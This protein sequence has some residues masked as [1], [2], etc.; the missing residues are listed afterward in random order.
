MRA[1]SAT[2]AALL[3]ALAAPANAQAQASADVAFDWFEYRGDDAVFATPL[4]A[5][6]YRNPVLAG[7][8]PDPSITRVGERYYLVNSTFTYF[9]A[10]PVFESTDLVHWTQIG[11]VV[12]RREQLDY[13]GLRMSRGMYAASIRHHDGRF[14]V[15][16]TSVDSGGNFIASAGD[17]AGPWSTLTWLPSIDGIDPSLFFDTD[18]SVYLLNN[19]PP[20][21]TP[22]YEGHR[23]IWMQRFDIATNQPVGPRKVLLNGGVDLA[24]KPIWIEGPH[25]YQRDG[26][27]YLSCAEGGTGPQHSQVVLRSRSVW[28]PYAPAP[29]NP[30]LTQRDL[31]AERAHPISNAGHVDLVDTSDGQWWAVFLASRPYRGD[32][33]NTGRE[34]FLLPVQWRDGWPSILP[35]GQPI[36]YIARAPAGM[37]APATQ[38]PLS[39]NFVWHDDFDHTMLQREWLTVRVPKHEVAD[40]RTRAGWL[41]LHASSQG[42]DGTGTPAFLA[43][44]QQHM[45]FTASTALEVPTQAGVSAGL[46]AFQNSTAWYALGI[47]RD[48]DAV[49][50]F[51]DKRD[52]AAT[53]TLAQTRIPATAQLRLQISGDGGAY[54]FAFDADGRGWQSLRRNDDA[55][56]LSTEKAGGFVGSVIGPFAQ[57]H[58]A[59]P[60]QD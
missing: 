53:T 50:V 29:N 26:W 49:Q 38:A 45:R 13:D 7:F 17:P 2:C 46:A 55:S 47:R 40:L 22:L 59:R 37:K 52:G 10:I 51:L 48:G 36:P 60:S 14:Y 25:L 43:R 1:L 42:L 39:G 12:D 3:M 4:P 44:R 54:S 11:N 21:G 15:V 5:G 30:I 16:G 32:R 31:P 58:P 20:E 41:T 34:T 33:Y 6:H 57:S 28:G 8:Y 23:A 9:P 56:F 18:G 35:A 27:Y 19:G 24:S